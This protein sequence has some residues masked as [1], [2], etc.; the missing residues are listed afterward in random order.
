MAYEPR[1]LDVTANLPS[2][3][4]MI[5]AQKNRV[6]LGAALGGA[7]QEGVG[8]YQQAKN[9]NVQRALQQAEAS[10]A[11]AEA[12][13]Y[14]RKENL[15]P[16][17]SLTPEEQKSL[18]DS[19]QVDPITGQRGVPNS[20]VLAARQ[21]AITSL[22][23]SKNQAEVEAKQ[24]E[25]DLAQQL[26]EQKQAYLELQ[27][28]IGPAAQKR[29]SLTA[30]AETGKSAKPGLVENLVG[31]VT[32][33]FA[34]S[35]TSTLAPA[36][37]AQQTGLAAQTQLLKGQMAPPDVTS[38]ATKQTGVPRATAPLAPTQT[39]TPASPS[40]AVQGHT[41]YPLSMPPA[42][43]GPIPDK[44]PTFMAEQPVNTGS[45]MP[46]TTPA[47]AAAVPGKTPV[48]VYTQEDYDALKD[49]DPY[50]DAQGMKI[51]GA[52]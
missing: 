22:T 8:A 33:R 28:K 15:V 9:F 17:G 34:P 38:T 23:Q 39:V 2:L 13:F 6:N 11:T 51:K 47:S 16:L 7:V 41:N 25:L 10:K 14:G 26:N 42:Q 52:K 5:E 18:G 44:S 37:Q 36:Y 1:N 31:A 3:D 19:V 12:G 4:S 50:I 30:A 48:S 46:Q 35:L 49:G 24:R 21:S 40:P 29:E 20:A 27:Q 45:A 43:V 32:S